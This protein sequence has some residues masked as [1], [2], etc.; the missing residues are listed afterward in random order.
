M[1]SSSSPGRR[2][3]FCSRRSATK[4]RGPGRPRL[5]LEFDFILFADDEVSG[6]RPALLG[7]ELGQQ[8]RLARRKQLLHLRSIHRLLQ[9]DGAGTKVAGAIRADGLFTD[10]T[11]TVLKDLRAAFGAFAEWFLAGEIHFGLPIAISLAEIEF[12]F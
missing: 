11:R 4:A 3:S 2:P 10:I 6:K 12:R 7:N 1:A 9:N 5:E 8:I